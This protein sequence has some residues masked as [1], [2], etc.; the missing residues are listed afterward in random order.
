ML[1]IREPRRFTADDLALI[2]ELACI[3]ARENFWAFRL[4][5]HPELKRSWFQKEVANAFQQLYDD[6]RKGERPKLLLAAPPQHGKT[7]QVTDFIAW[8]AGRHPEL[9][10]IFGSYGEDLGVGVNLDLQRMI[11]SERYARVFPNTRISDANTNT[12]GLGR[13]LRNS[14]LLEFVGHGGSFRNT[15]VNG[16]VTGQGLDFGI[17]DDP[18]KGRAEAQSKTIRDK[19]WAWLTDDF[20]TRFADAAA[21]LMIMT[22]WHIDDPGGRF[23]DL[24]PHTRVLKFEAIATQD[25]AH[26]KAGEALF[27]DLKSLPF[28]LERKAVLSAASWEALYQQ[29]PVI[30]GGDLFPIEKFRIVGE[31]ER[32]MIRH[33]VR[34]WDK[35]GTEG[36]G[37]YTCGVLM[38]Q[39]RDQTFAIEDVRRGQWGALERERHIKQTA[40]LDGRKVHVYVEQEPGSGGKESAEASVRMLAGF[41]AFADKVTGA[42][43]VRADPYAA[44]VQAGNVALKAAGWNKPFLDEHEVYPGKYKDQV[45]SAAGSFNKLIANPPRVTVQGAI[46]GLS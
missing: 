23:I 26:R 34:Y 1:D 28:L 17:L 8:I 7:K 19:T 36:G 18:I 37:A 31:I 16:Q 39:M 42:K 27:P 32:G 20:F 41:N 38:H 13:Y 25:E 45:D 11:T 24:F 35:A 4:W 46:R 2:E 15:T 21:L 22:R 6:Y 10:S 3:D 14:S 9:K 5:M 29:N 12:G 30:A 44:Q 43:E 33:S 40:Q